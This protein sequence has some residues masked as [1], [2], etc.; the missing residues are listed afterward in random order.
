MV[1]V[2]TSLPMSSLAIRLETLL[3]ALKPYEV[4]EIKLNDN[5]SQEISIV[6]KSTYKEIVVLDVCN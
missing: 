3:K 6:V 2:K 1:E 5:Q 4:V